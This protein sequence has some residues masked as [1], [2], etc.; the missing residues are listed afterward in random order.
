MFEY[1]KRTDYVPNPVANLGG[2]GEDA[3]A[4]EQDPVVA[5]LLEAACKAL[6]DSEV[7]LN[8]LDSKVGD[9]D[10]GTQMKLGAESLLKEKLPTK[11]L[12]QLFRVI[13][14]RLAR[15]MGGSSEQM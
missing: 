4:Y 2:G 13:G 6:I 3:S 12:G 1:A 5:K 10:T 7:L 9:G 15:D 8:K 11:D 14:Q